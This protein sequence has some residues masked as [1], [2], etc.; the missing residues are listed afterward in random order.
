MPLRNSIATRGIVLARTDF[1]EADRIITLLTPD[2]GKVKVI[3]KGVRRQ[4]S[5]MAAGVELFSVSQVTYLPGSREIGTLVSSRL[6]THYGNIVKDITRTMLGY[7]LLKRINRATED[8]PG[9]EYFDLLSSSIQGLNEPELAS[10][11]VEL[12]FS[13]QLLKIS[14]HSPHL[15]RDAAG[16]QLDS[17][18]NYVFDFDEMYFQLRTD[19]PYSSRHIKLLRLAS[20]LKE[21]GSLKQITD[22]AS[23]LPETLQ[24][25]RTMLA[26]FVRV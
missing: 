17:D 16:S 2:Y 3:V 9:E 14:G 18:K 5:K 22:A 23:S 8:A 4:A 6:E 15:S 19:A 11:L 24:L 10:E 1:Q 12:W 20:G 25:A 13:M 26:K 7:E 21:P